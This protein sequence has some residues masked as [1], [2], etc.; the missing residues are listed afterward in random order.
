MVSDRTSVFG[1]RFGFLLV[2][3]ASVFCFSSEAAIAQPSG[4]PF[5]FSSTDDQFLSCRGIATRNT[6]HC[7][8]V[9]DF[10]D[11]QLCAGLASSSQD[12]CRSM[13]DRNLQLSCY[14]MAFA[15]NFPS[16]CRDITDV[17]LQ[18]FCYGASSYNPTHCAD[19]QD[20]N[21]R[22]LCLAMS[23]RSS[24]HCA[25]ISDLKDRQF[26]Y[27]V[28]TRDSSYCQ[29]PFEPT[30]L[31]LS[32]TIRDF[33]P[34]FPDM[35]YRVAYEKGIVEPVLG[36]DDK[37]V[38]TTSRPFTTTTHG[39][40]LF[41]QW[42]RDV[43]GVNLRTEFPIRLTNSQAQPGVFTYD[44]SDFFPIDG[45]L[46]GN[47]NYGH[48]YFFTL[49]MHTQFTYQGGEV[50]QFRGDDD[51]F[52]YVN[53][54][55]VIDIGGVHTPIQDQV[56]LDAVAAQ[57]GLVKGESYDLDF[58]FAERYCCGSNFRIQTSILL[59]KA[60]EQQ[61]GHTV[62]QYTGDTA[63]DFH[64]PA[65]LSAVLLD[66]SVNPPV[67]VPDSLL[68]FRLGQASCKAPTDAQGR[69]S[70]SMTPQTAA[71]DQPI[72][73]EFSGD[74]V[75][76]SSTVSA[77][78]AVRR[79]QT[80][81]AITS[82][83]AGPAG[84]VTVRAVL[85]EDGS[86]PLE[87]R[88]VVFQ[89]GT[90]MATATTGADGAAT[91]RLTLPAGDHPL[92]ASFDGDGF[93]EPATES[94][95]LRAL[96]S[97]LAIVPQP[98]VAPAGGSL[99]VTAEIQDG[100]GALSGE[101]IGFQVLSGPNADAVGSCEA[102]GCASDVSGRA[103]FRYTGGAAGRDTVRAWLDANR[104][105]AFDA[106]EAQATA[107]LHWTVRH[108]TEVRLSAPQGGDYHDPVRL[109]A[110]LMNTTAEPDVPVAGALLTL[111][112]QAGSCSARTD[113]TGTASCYVTPEVEAGSY[114]LVAAFAGDGRHLPSQ[115]AGT[116]AVS[117][118]QA[119]LGIV[120]STALEAGAVTVQAVLR[121]DGSLPIQGREVVFRSGSVSA[122]AITDAEGLATATLGLPGGEHSLEADFAGDPFYEQAGD[123][124][125]QLLVYERGQFVVWGGN[126]PTLAQALPL[127]ETYQ[128]WGSKWADQ[129]EKG[130][131]DYLTNPSFKGYA[132]DVYPDTASWR[133]RPANSRRPPQSVPSYMSVILST[134]IVKEGDVE[135]GNI[136]GIGIVRV[137]DPAAFIPDPGHEAF[138]VLLAILPPAPSPTP[139]GTRPG[140]PT[141]VSATA[142]DGFAEVRWTPPADPGSSPVTGYFVT[143]SPG[144][145]RFAVPAGETSRIVPGL[146]FGT[147]YQFTVTAAN[148]A[149]AATASDPSPAVTLL[150]VPGS[151]QAVAAVAGNGGATVTWSAPAETGGSPVTG[152]LVQPLPDGA[153]VSVDGTA[154]SAT[155]TGLDNGTSYTFV[156]RARN[157]LGLGP[158]SAPSAA[159]LPASAPAAPSAV[160]ASAGDRDATVYWTIPA[161]NGGSAVTGYRI[162]ASPGGA[163]ATV[164]GNRAHVRFTGLDNA[165]T[166]RFTVVAANAQGDGPASAPSDEVVPYGHPAAP[167]SIETEQGNG[168]ARVTWAAP[169]T[170]GGRSITGY[171]VTTEPGSLSSAVPAGETS[172][173][174]TG[175]S[176]GTAYTF[177]V[178]A[179]NHAGTGPASASGSATPETV[180]GEPTAVQA[181]G[182]DKFA[183]VTWTAP[184]SDGGS[185]VTGYTVVTYPGK[186]SMSVAAGATTARIDGLTNGKVYRFAVRAVNA[187]G[188]GPE[189]PVSN[190]VTPA[191]LPGAPTGVLAVVNGAASVQ[192]SWQ[193]PAANGGAPITGYTVTSTPAGA[194][195]NAAANA[196]SATVSGLTVGTAYT[197]N[198]AAINKVGTGPASQVSGSVVAARLPGAPANVTAVSGNLS[199]TVT[200][201]APADNGFSPISSYR[202]TTQPATSTTTG[203][204]GQTT[205]TVTGLANGTAYTFL[206]TAV[207]A[208]G[209]GPLST[210]SAP[211]SPATTPGAPGNVVAQLAGDAAVKVTWSA[212]ASNGGS[213]VTGY[214]VTSSPDGLTATVDGAATS[215][216]VPGLAVGTT[217]TFTVRAANAKGT[218]PASAPSNAVKAAA[219]PGA[220]TGVTAADG[221][222]SATVTWTAPASDGSS[223]ITGYR[224]VASPGGI[225]VS[226]NASATTATVSGLQNGTEYI[227][228]V[229]ASN[230]VAE[231]AVS[232]PSNPVTP[233]TVPG[234]PAG[235]TAEVGGNAAALV[236]WTPPSSDGGALIT[237]YVVTSEPG[238]LTASMSG[239]ATS[240]KVTGLTVGTTYTFTVAAV[241]RKGAGPA[242][243]ASNPMVAE[244]RPEDP[245]EVTL[246]SV[247]V[248]PSEVTGGAGATGTVT[249]SGPAPEGGLTVTLAS[250]SPTA[251]V[252]ASA[253]VVAGAATATFPVTTRVVSSVTDV[254]ITASLESVSQ[255]T[256]L[257]VRPLPPNTPPTAEIHTP[258]DGAEIT[259]M[260]QIV[261]TAF[262][263]SFRDYV[264][265]IAPAG[266]TTFTTIATGNAAVVGGVLGA[267]D[268][269]MLLNDLYTVRL[270]VS[271]TSGSSVSTEVA[272]AVEGG[273][274]VGNFTLSFEDLSV[275]VSG[276]PIAVI[277]NYDSRDKRVG[278][279][280]YGWTLELRQGSYRNNRKPGV[281]WEIESGFLPCQTV[282]E[283]LS[284]STV[285]RLSD[286]E[287]Y[288]F[289]L[290]L[291]GP[292]TMFG[293]CFAEAAFE[294]VDGSIPGAKL[295][296]L[297]STEVFYE[298]GT[299]EVVD[300][301]TLDV[302]E[303]RQVRLTT[304]DGRIFDLE[305]QKGVT[306]LQD[307]NGN[308]LVI[309]P[310]GITH[311]TGRSVSF[312]R[313][314]QGRITRI[315]DPMG[316]S[317]TYQYDA[318]GDLVGVTDRLDETTTFTY[319]GNH[320]VLSIEDPRGITPLRYEYEN[321]GRLVA[322]IDAEG[323]RAE[324]T[325]D[326]AA[327]QEILYDRRG[328]AT[329]VS[330][331]ESG[332]VLAKTDALGNTISFTYDADGNKL[333]ETDALGETTSFS[334]DAQGNLLSRTDPEGNT[335]SY[336]Y[337]ARGQELTVTDALG[338]TVTNTYDSSGNLLTTTDALG[339]VTTNTYDARGNVL[340][341]RDALGNTTTRQ[342]DAS[343]N[344]V[345]QIDSIG[346]TTFIYDANGN[347]LSR[348]FIRS[349]ES[350]QPVTVRT[351]KTYDAGN[352]VLAETDGEG[353]ATTYEYDALGRLTASTDRN[354]GR[355]EYK[356]DSRGNREQVIFPD[357]TYESSTYDEEGNRLT[358]TDRAGRT[359]RFEHD[360]LNRLTRTL[361]PDGSSSR[362]EYDAASRVTASID[363]RG[364]RTVQIYDA[365]GRMIEVADALGHITRH[366]YDA[367]GNRL[368][369]TDALG[370]VTTF[371][372]D[373]L[374][375]Q[376]RK[377]FNDGTSIATTYDALG[378]KTS[379]TDQAGNT[380]T[381]EYD[382]RGN[383]I[384]V[385]GALGNKTSFGYDQ[386]GNKVA[387]TDAN[388]H[389]TRWAYDNSGRVVRHTLPLGM[390]ATF[391]YDANGN[392]VS[393]TDFNG[394]T[395]NLL[396][397]VRNR[398]IEKRSPDGTVV[399]YTYTVDGR[400][401]TIDGGRGTTAYRYDEG[402][403]LTGVVEPDGVETSYTYDSAGNRTSMVTPSGT[404][405]YTYDALNRLAS[406]IE[407]AGGLTTYTYDAVGNLAGT[408]LPNGTSA[409][410]TYDGLNR[411]VRLINR[412]QD[413]G[414]ISSYTYTLGAA[415][416]RLQIAEGSGRIVS[417][418]YDPL[419]RLIRESI[420]DPVNG[421]EDIS[422]TYDP[423]GNRLTR[424]N[425]KGTVASAYDANDRLL[426][427]GSVAFTY[428]D[429]GN[430]LERVEGSAATTYTYDAENRLVGV[431]APDRSVA[432]TYDAAGI[433]LSAAVDG[434]VTRYLNDRNREHVQV[435]EERDGAD[436]LIVRYVHGHDLISQARGTETRYYHSD[437][438][439]SVR[440]LTDGTQAVT[441]TYDFDAFGKLL[442]ST[443]TTPNNY[444][445]AGEQLDPNVG[446]YYLR[447]RYYDPGMGR[448]VTSDDFPP[449][450]FD[451][452][453]LHRY[454]YANN[455]PVNLIDPSGHF[456][457]T[458]D[459]LMATVTI[460]NILN[461]MSSTLIQG[462]I[463]GAGVQIFIKPGFALRN[464]GLEMI[465]S[466]PP[467]QEAWDKAFQTYQNGHTLLQLGAFSIDRANQIA[468]IVQVGLGARD[469]AKALLN[470]PRASLSMVEITRIHRFESIA[471]RI[472]TQGLSLLARI[473]RSSS[474]TI[475][476]TL[477]REFSDWSKV[478][479][480]GV[481]LLRDLQDVLQSD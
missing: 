237:G 425:S 368:S 228:T 435:V 4:N 449:N 2:L 221:D 129:V 462:A 101:R 478:I 263:P 317:L 390:D 186:Q 18:R 321:D 1:R 76:A 332:N 117:R 450:P 384:G 386:A 137:I 260:T 48:N 5:V 448:F 212:P 213:P 132:D 206:V 200:W 113:A 377:V 135:A 118:E 90:V 116:L 30:T 447:A 187:L 387:Q 311:S 142:G 41:D 265:A 352:R 71:S 463:I 87:G 61:A 432:Y 240:G 407:P 86:L 31:E 209:A 371:V 249:L 430:T 25:A 442:T 201:T 6:S 37:P 62:L 295:D 63:G 393:S 406:V 413:L 125:G 359:T 388:G 12:P 319:D 326:L 165:A 78:F 281:G 288:R 296:I 114:G 72:A 55:L 224:I 196:T 397:D 338:R 39:R 51:V 446:F 13:T 193:A 476:R 155:L 157:A 315:T 162:V 433:R 269:T 91:A 185:P 92:T 171:L 418:T 322:T 401:A 299:N 33:K 147:A 283:T 348:S 134:R 323:N 82:P 398:L 382:A 16:N 328:N 154:T 170:D 436:N 231:G 256:V 81:V 358:S 80:R 409:S 11:R 408:V 190:D 133:T 337:N 108:A 477:S 192:V 126:E 52:V 99:A 122:T 178:T 303:P 199:A 376:I 301:D 145:Q 364:N 453:S 309:T 416:N 297:G 40:N 79:E 28:S 239:S 181:T 258:E 32:A 182:D 400:I 307:L 94:Q 50:F 473:S 351:S 286:A 176:N 353:H 394:Q 226:A 234:A 235:V 131:F 77:T 480:E 188:R 439:G 85:R 375:R 236:S 466:D 49:E 343:G 184:A 246:S 160:V 318:A 59:E 293:G 250:A 248:N 259:S 380:T 47:F 124:L 172:R 35:Q 43:P 222:A 138:G 66:D 294:F 69:A 23:A 316:K 109:T 339:N 148:R 422:Y 123:D 327:Q 15:P 254:T 156:V 232:A 89:A 233:A 399:F 424:T 334:Y 284:H 341:T 421:N 244:S 347:E 204:G 203:H 152:Y 216:T 67:A 53:K 385:T 195:V 243:A 202:V 26:C 251:I 70:C 481:H 443:G 374:G 121:E 474:V 306:R 167:G 383:L 115:A 461:A 360:A 440:A 149:G 300:L 302:Y 292:A 373:A 128:F 279:F 241:N 110:L 426:T 161:A 291:T 287:V 217:Y 24:S 395:T 214:T 34:D 354:G 420:L 29:V 143:M 17:N 9:S 403:R 245:D 105:G 344:L 215:A 119:T 459:G 366:T 467:T 97:Q 168:A 225:T 308:N 468:G 44:V 346:E 370:H 21:T 175:L 207:N 410:Y 8:S 107:A 261:G 331:D 345:R 60:P 381:Y 431:Q 457:T 460:G 74:A 270:T 46:F 272:Y 68:T 38:Y 372:Y 464:L 151:P 220:P 363:G 45:Q 391:S 362:K 10:N 349:D 429:N 458:V 144:G 276:L 54:R 7:S 369:T 223:P 127:G 402:D 277:R 340:T 445:F 180:P 465:M 22:Q 93:Y 455:D 218:G 20:S 100:G 304:R 355:T 96:A 392:L 451:P 333:S 475:V 268:P 227:F 456:A 208:V 57:I 58:F 255:S 247:S 242:S 330:Y 305:L 271:T 367:N 262:A 454:V 469:F 350:G 412:R 437:G 298:N 396:Y 136:A 183:T 273:Q 419:L 98:N 441:D 274:K 404:T 471:I 84:E 335:T 150:S 166:Y 153:P 336:T 194:T 438:L 56:S 177:Q 324:V 163:S 130:N 174:V 169:S 357:G 189:S 158:D 229:R 27:G 164:P 267:F 275:P 219:S 325:H 253:Q 112:S 428:D 230:A 102:A 88:Q 329:V 470:V 320:R 75:H 120:S 257:R 146:A 423:V 179:I 452:E 310:A 3:L 312:Q 197:F 95:I 427:A 73:V 417:Y 278:D 289:R 389:I 140:T 65:T 314:G 342:Y 285:V 103:T 252:P 479:E 159:V 434:A 238:G 198:V 379:E 266:E 106:G 280:G 356:Y 472:E 14:G 264:L 210:P 111:T 19:I 411:L 205:A 83:T 405:R 139:A 191:G 104:N 414:E 42:Y 444:L 173:L 282:K 378:R 64:D 365:A 313:D 415:G 36:P 290:R 141:A 361:L 211:V